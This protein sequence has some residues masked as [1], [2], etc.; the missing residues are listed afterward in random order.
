MLIAR[1]IQGHCHHLICRGLLKGGER[2]AF[3]GMSVMMLTA[4]HL[5]G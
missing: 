4:Q 3:D 2:V 1:A 5:L